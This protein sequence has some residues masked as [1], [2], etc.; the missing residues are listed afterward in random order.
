MAAGTLD[1]AEM[2]YPIAFVRVFLG[3]WERVFTEH[4]FGSR[5]IFDLSVIVCSKD[6]KNCTQ[7][8][9]GERGENHGRF[10]RLFSYETALKKTNEKNKTEKKR[11]WKTHTL[12]PA[13]TR[14]EFVV[15]FPT[16]F[17]KSLRARSAVSAASLSR[18]FR[19]RRS[20]WCPSAAP[21]AINPRVCISLLISRNLAAPARHA[22][23]RDPDSPAS[24]S[25]SRLINRL[26]FY[27]RWGS[28]REMKTLHAG[29]NR[30]R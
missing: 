30:S 2:S 27:A 18:P 13:P 11:H 22:L 12:K 4:H 25:R 14:T 6:D 23:R 10:P 8:R 28:L 5:T 17:I 9:E 3:E 29:A 21:L 15:R 7:D 26:N 20:D 24:I 1:G 19:A 16:T